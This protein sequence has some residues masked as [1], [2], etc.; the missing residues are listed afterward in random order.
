MKH[1]FQIITIVI[2]LFGNSAYASDSMKQFQDSLE[3]IT[4]ESTASSTV[5]IVR[6]GKVF[7]TS[8]KQA[9]DD[10]QFYI[11]SITKHMTAYMMLVTL[12]EKHPKAS[13][14]ELLSQK[15]NVLF[16]D[17]ALLKAIGK[18]WISEVSLLDLLTHKS[19][20]TDY[21]FDYQGGLAVPGNFDKPVTSV[22]LLKSIS[23]NPEKT[24]LYSNSNY[25]LAGKL[26]EELHHDTFDHIFEKLIKTPAGMQLSFAPVI[27]NYFSLK[28]LPDFS[29]LTHNS[30]LHLG[31]QKYSF[32]DMANAVGTGNVVSTA[33]DLAKWG[34]Y[35]TSKASK[36]ITTLMFDNYGLDDD[37]DIVNLGLTTSDTDHLGA[38]ISWKGGQDSYATV[39]G[40][41]PKSNTFIIILSNDMAD[42]DRPNTDFNRLMDSFISWISE[43]EELVSLNMHKEK[44]TWSW[45]QKLIEENESLKF[46]ASYNEAHPEAEAGG[47]GPFALTPYDP[48]HQGLVGHNTS[49]FDF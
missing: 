11:G 37:E 35:L 48:D 6:G 21:Q 45:T 9:N 29:H 20:L 7:K 28:E 33:D 18:D 41:A 15:L 46:A 42:Q 24:Y 3:K 32:I 2:T 14:K 31:N 27:E 36:E 17:S 43:P 10:T 44:L 19:G 40:W 5:A 47:Y 38:L 26:L 13:L 25:L 12:H 23:F 30:G 22:K 34:A 1:F 39:F 49:S 16:P 4:H 8:S